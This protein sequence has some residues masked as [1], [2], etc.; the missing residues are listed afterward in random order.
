MGIKDFVYRFD[1]M[2][3]GMWLS[4]TAVDHETLDL[5]AEHGIKFTILGPHQAKRIRK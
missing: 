2:P 5:L 3:E 4:E 1:R